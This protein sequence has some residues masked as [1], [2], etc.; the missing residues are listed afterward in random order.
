MRHTRRTFLVASSALALLPFANRAGFASKGPQRHAALTRVGSVKFAPGF[1][2]FDWVDPQ[3]PKG[4]D[5]RLADIGGFDNLNAFTFK[6][7]AASGLSLLNDSLMTGSLD[8][9]ATVYGLIA[10]WASF[11][12]D[13]AWTTFGIN[14]LARFQ[15]GSAITPEDIVF[16]FEEQKK[17]DPVR[18]ITYRDVTSVEKS[19]DRE[20]TF[21]FAGPGNR[22]LPFLVSQLLIVP[23]HYWTGKNA[24]GVTRDLSHTTLEPPLGS[25]PYKVKS[26]EPSRTIVY[27][28]VKDYWA[29]D[30]PVMRG[31]WNFDTIRFDSYR[32]DVPA[33]EAFKAGQIDLMQEGS[34]KRWATEYIFPAVTGGRVR[35]LE[36][37]LATVATAQAFI[38]NMRRPKFA[39]RNVRQVFDLAFDFETANK[40]LFYGLYQRLNSYFDNSELA[41]RGLPT[42]RELELLE[43][44]RGQV[45]DEVFTTEFKSTVNATPEQRRNNLRKASG[46]LDQAG[47]KLEGSRRM[48]GKTGE[49]LTVEVLVSDTTF[50]R[51][52]L[53]YQQALEKLGI[54]MS[55]RVVD[56]PQYVERVKTYDFD[57]IIDSFPQS[58]A[59]GNEQR[60]YWGSQSADRTAS[61]NTMGIKNPAV[62]A[63]V[64]KLIY[65]PTR[66][67]VVAA[68][69]A[70]DR[71]L[72]WNRYLVLQW[73]RPTEWLAYWNKFGRPPKTPS[74][75]VGWLQTWWTDTNGG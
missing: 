29:S 24:S 39:D 10:E 71:V 59:P 44:L 54:R 56:A 67:D 48:N 55:V 69:R 16:S 18:A 70:L 19:G 49:A 32:D 53:P 25:G 1:T 31:Q 6:G 63:L 35:K 27:E 46:L 75:A 40:N 33:F 64:E 58:H 13:C 21:H 2:N 57:M 12:D 5:L 26:V 74:Q 50:D 14:P 45:P 17:A 72:L 41:A 47:W 28:R 65:A 52:L 42:G 43:E 20:V 66:E 37:P 61:R 8:E 34:S 22:D 9:P 4:G 36:V 60:E 73:Y 51:V 15:D 23:R 3:A 38:F 7:L 62:D 11:P 30:L 68:T